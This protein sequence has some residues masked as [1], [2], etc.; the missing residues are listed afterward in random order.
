MLTAPTDTG[1]G[2]YTQKFFKVARS[3]TTSWR[4]ATP[5][6]PGPASATAGSAAAPIT[7]PR[8]STRSAPTPSSTASSPTTRGPGTSARQE[9]VLYLNHA[10]VNPPIDRNKPVEAGQ[11]RLHHHPEGNRR[12]HLRLRRQGGRHQ[13]GAHA[14]QFPRP[15]HGPGDQR[16]EHGGDVHRADEHARH[17]A[18]LPARPTSSPPRRRARRGIIR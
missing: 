13:L 7:R 9:A 14:L 15:E 11:G 8:S 4:S 5:S 18:D 1:S 2:G 3:A 6:R 16:P 17:Q 12:R 10:L